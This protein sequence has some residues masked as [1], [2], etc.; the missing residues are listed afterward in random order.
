MDN[1][2]TTSVH[3][4]IC[5]TCGYTCVPHCECHEPGTFRE[6]RDLPPGQRSVVCQDLIILEDKAREAKVAQQEASEWEEKVKKAM[7]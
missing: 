6:C 4:H 2:V 3:L 5:K 7:P 1:K